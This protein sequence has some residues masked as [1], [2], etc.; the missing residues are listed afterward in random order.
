VRVARRPVERPRPFRD[1]D[2]RVAREVRRSAVRLGLDDAPDAQVAARADDLS[3]AEERT[4]EHERVALEERARKWVEGG[5]AP[6]FSPGA[7]DAS[8]TIV[9]A[10]VCS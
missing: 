9:L 4:S 5:H 6:H 3:G 1:P 10:L 8:A 2:A 7:N